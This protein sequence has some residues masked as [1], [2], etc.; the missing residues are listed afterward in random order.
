[1]P[2]ANIAATATVKPTDNCAIPNNPWPLVQPSAIRAPNSIR[3]PAANATGHSAN[4][5]MAS[6]R[7]GPDRRDRHADRA[8]QLHRRE[9]TKGN[10]DHQGDLPRMPGGCRNVPGNVVDL[11]RRRDGI[12]AG[13]PRADHHIGQRSPE[14]SI[15]DNQGMPGPAAGRSGYRRRR[16]N[17]AL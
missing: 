3:N 6:Q 10:A 12:Q 11:E 8:G 14:R 1:M 2:P 5:S 9:C 15:S 4:P 16:G 17:H 7:S 13:Y